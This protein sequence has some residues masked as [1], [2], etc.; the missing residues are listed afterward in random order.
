MRNEETNIEQKTAKDRWLK[1]IW[2]L[3][4]TIFLLLLIA[5]VLGLYSKIMSKAEHLKAE[6]KAN[7]H[8]VS[9]PVN[10]VVQ[11][12]TPEAIN[13][14]VNLPGIV[15]PWVHLKILSEIQGT[16]IEV[17]LKEGDSVKKGD[18]IVRIDSR[19][20]KIALNSAQAS[21][22]LAMAE[23]KRASALF[24]KELITPEAMENA[25]TRVVKLKATMENAR[26]QLERCTIKAPISGIINHLDAKV[27]LLLSVSD[28]IAEILQIDRV[29]AV[30]GI[31]ESDVSAVRN[32]SRVDLTINA[33]SG[34]KFSGYKYYLSSAPDTSARLYRLVLTIDNMDGEILPGMFVRAE[35]IKSHVSDS[36]VI[37]LYTV[38]SRKDERFVYIEEHGKARVQIV[39]LGILDGWR[40]QIRSGLKPG[41]HVI[42]VG[43]RDIDEGQKVKV[44]R[45]I[46]NS[47]ELVR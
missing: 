12:V 17:P 35:I 39:E 21:Y 44:L 26:L 20:Y 7:I 15:E 27:G 8:S 28:P 6:K 46:S 13:D 31:P 23:R 9:K 40:I 42:V 25:E 41:D 43:H 47:K 14:R 11:N 38:I 24:K 2:R 5:V 4:P 37:P 19:E 45:T 18:V 30:V 1:R 22:E 16:V 34:R 10:V 3:L 36:L 29:K 32:I 33:L